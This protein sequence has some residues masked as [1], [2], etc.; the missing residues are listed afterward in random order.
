MKQL[1]GIY[2]GIA[3]AVLFSMVVDVYRTDA[4][5]KLLHSARCRTH[6]QRCENNC[7]DDYPGGSLARMRCYERCRAKEQT[8][9]QYGDDEP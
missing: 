5:S 1:F 2:A 4:H 6:E 3:I 8:C 9:G 7:N